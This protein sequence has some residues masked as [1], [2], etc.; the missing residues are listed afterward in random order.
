MVG[1]D[2]VVLTATGGDSGLPV[3]Y[4]ITTNPVSGVATLTDN[5]IVIENVG[6][7][8]VT[9]S[10][11]GNALYEAADNV[12]HT[13]RISANELFLPTLFTPN[14]DG[15]NDH[16]ILRGGG[17][18][19]QI[20]F[21]ILDR[22]NNLVYHTNSWKALTEQGW[23]GIHNGKVQPLGTYVWVISGKYTNGLPLLINGKNTDIIRLLR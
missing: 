9:A 15:N 22:D 19:A 10:Q 12:S 4:S 23:D 1:Q 17:G 21:S 14:G 3:T 7:V 18:V 5:T 11:A 6:T 20:E 16:F 13:F 2:P 8:T